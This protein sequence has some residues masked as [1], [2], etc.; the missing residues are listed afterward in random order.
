MFF[1]GGSGGRPGRGAAVLRV[2]ARRRFLPVPGRHGGRGSPPPA[3]QFPFQPSNGLLYSYGSGRAVGLF[4]PLHPKHVRNALH[5][6]VHAVEGVVKEV[7]EHAKEAGEKAIA[8]AFKKAQETGGN[9][10]K[11]VT[12]TVT[13][14][15]TNAITHAAEGLGNLGQ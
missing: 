14:T 10:V 4:T 12:E 13:H 2:G 3:D 15:V 9:V 7:V 8:E 5:C 11:E 1:T 6:E